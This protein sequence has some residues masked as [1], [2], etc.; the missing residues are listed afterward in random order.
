[1]KARLVILSIALSSTISP[2]SNAKDSPVSV[3]DVSPHQAQMAAPQKMLELFV[4]EST[5][6]IVGASTLDLN[7][8]I[9][10]FKRA[11][12]THNT[13]ESFT[14][15]NNKIFFQSMSQEPFSV[16]VT[17]DDDPNAPQYKMMFVPSNVPIGFQ[18]KLKPDI[19]YV[20]KSA[21]REQTANPESDGYSTDLSNIATGVA[22]F[23]AD[24][25]NLK[26]LPEGFR[27]DD[28]FAKPPYYIGNVLMNP[29]LRII[30]TNY[31]V[32]VMNA[33]NRANIDLQLS[34]P[35]FATLSPTTGVVEDAFEDERAR[36]VGFYPRKVL[37][38]GQSTSL[39]LIHEPRRL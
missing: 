24:R 9:T 32:Y 33:N 13:N 14:I 28:D 37:A 22:K 4:E 27:V 29:E 7:V 6:A 17:E 38:P 5:T 34:A 1:M 31:D 10:P 16:F 8:V 15:D 23:L 25:R 26:H 39:I 18:I 12:V 2:I 35:D 11:K 3:D 20:P 19:P 36:L 30:G 21:K